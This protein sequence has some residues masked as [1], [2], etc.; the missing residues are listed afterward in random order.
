MRKNSLAVAVFACA[1]SFGF[2]TLFYNANAET[3]EEAK[4]AV[5]GAEVRTEAP[6]GIRFVTE[7]NEAYKAEL[8]ET[9]ATDTY[10]YEWGTYLSFTDSTGTSYNLNAKT[11]KWIENDTR[12]NTALVGIPDTDYTTPI[13][14]QS[15]VKIYSDAEKTNLVDTITVAESV[16][17][18][19]AWTASWALNAGYDDD[20]LYTYTEAIS[21]ATLTLDKESDT[22]LYGTEIQLVATATEGYGIAWRSSNEDVAKVD[23]NGKVTT[24]GV[25]TATITAT[26][27]NAKDTYEVE[28]TESPESQLIETFYYRKD[29]STHIYHEDFTHVKGVVS[30]DNY[31]YGSS[32][33]G[34]GRT[35]S[36]GMYMTLSSEYMATLF[37]DAKIAE[38]KFDIIL[39]VD[40]KRVAICVDTTDKVILADNKSTSSVE[41]DNVTY[42]TYTVTITRENYNTYGKDTDMMIR[43]IHTGSSKE[44]NL[45][46]S[47]SSTFFYLDN[48]TVV[49][50]EIKLYENKLITSLYKSGATPQTLSTDNVWNGKENVYGINGITSNNSG[51][52][53][54]TISSDYIA[55][56]LAI[57]GV[58]AITFDIILTASKQLQLNGNNANFYNGGNY[59][60]ST[61]TIEGVTYYIYHVRITDEYYEANKDKA[62]GFRYVG[63]ASYEGTT[64]A[65]SSCF[66]VDNLALVKE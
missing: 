15:Y 29:A 40:A 20:I 48:L 27:G 3:T 53:L 59:T 41:I 42:Y 12:W 66:F 51:T 49:E 44:G 37:A 30:E 4:F 24:V 6:S 56:L 8:A 63:G 46:G 17:R 62:F 1:M 50:G 52:M 13:T 25:G 16:T 14:A 18:S 36:S 2:G 64:T 58:K 34:D 39:S 57:D 28:A 23:K 22:V 61:E 31:A 45:V 33:L 9:Y 19:I 26:L 10:T 11:E 32:N 60:V 54:M 47:G 55:E 7:V 5:L 35:N 65:T 21:N 43:Y 38:I